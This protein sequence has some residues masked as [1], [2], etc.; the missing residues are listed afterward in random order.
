MLFEAFPNPF[1]PLTTIRF[2]LGASQEYA[3]VEVHDL[4][5]R[6]IKTIFDG[7]VAGDKTIDWDG[8]DDSGRMV[9][10]GQYFV[11]LRTRDRIDV[12][13]ITLVK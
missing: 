5:G 3:T 9:A 1:N 8:R 10:A 11:R 13:K 4:L 2:N 7:Q 12:Q 6:Q